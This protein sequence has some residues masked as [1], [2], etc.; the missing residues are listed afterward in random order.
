MF[1]GSP[2]STTAFSRSNSQN[3]KHIG[4]NLFSIE[5]ATHCNW[6]SHPWFCVG[7][8]HGIN[9]VLSKKSVLPLVRKEIRDY[10]KVTAQNF[11]EH[12]ITPNY[13]PNTTL[14]EAYHLFE[15]ELLKALNQL[16]PLKTIKCTDRQKHP[17]HNKFIKEQKRVVKNREKNM[18]KIQT[19]SSVSGIH[20]GKEH[21]Q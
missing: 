14:D 4:S 12:Y 11:T 18:E 7:P 6:C 3:G 21:V 13:S 8:L 9:R 15:E 5:D 2:W 19:R 16:A 1:N 17:W 20:K 10:S